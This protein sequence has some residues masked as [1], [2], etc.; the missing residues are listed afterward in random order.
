[1]QCRLL[2]SMES[3]GVW[4]MHDPEFWRRFRRLGLITVA[5]CLGCCYLAIAVYTLGPGF[6]DLESVSAVSGF[7]PP[8]DRG[9]IEGVVCDVLGNPL[10]SASVKIL[11]ARVVS[12]RQGRFRVE[13]VP[14]GSVDLQIKAPGFQEA[15]VQALVEP[16]IN[17]PH[18]KYDTGLWPNEF[19]VRF[20][21]FTNSL[22]EADTR[23]LFGLVE[24]VNP[25]KDPIY[26][27]RIEV[28][29][30][31]GRIVCDFLES[32][33]ILH[34]IS[35][36]HN[37]QLVIEPI[38]AYV[39]PPRS[40]VS[41]ELDALPKPLRGNYHL[42]LAYASPQDHSRGRLV[43]LHIADEMDYDPDLDPHTPK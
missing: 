43:A 40:A 14:L 42:W 2:V 31:A 3:L 16:G 18:I 13:N 36:T 29:D 27:S 20:H 7:L 34:H 32:V 26:I 35:Q 30:P 23:L 37:L 6:M 24:V 5:L 39:I 28:K 19:Y 12:D 1:M 11:D 25:G 22:E 17:Y 41:F 33:E 9:V 10:P 21:A 8:T 15:T 4:V 38:P